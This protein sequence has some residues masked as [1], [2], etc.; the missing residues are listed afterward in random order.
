MI[1]VKDFYKSFGENQVLRGLSLDIYP[2]ETLAVIGRSGCGKS[3]LLKHIM[4][5]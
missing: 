2:G 1:E 3:V 4:G 5:F